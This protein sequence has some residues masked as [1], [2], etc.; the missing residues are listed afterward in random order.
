[1]N[2][3]LYKEDGLSFPAPRWKSL[4]TKQFWTK[5]KEILKY[6]GEEERL[7]KHFVPYSLRHFYG[8]TRI[9]NGTPHDI[10]C[11]N[12]GVDNKYL[13]KHYDHSTN[14]QFTRELTRMKPQAA[15][16]G[17]RLLKEGEDYGKDFVLTDEE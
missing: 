6:T 10:L 4:T 8:T 16:L 17:G 3:L 1:M 13:R 12:M 15:S 9:Q 5:F 2:L 14:R 7:G 11:R